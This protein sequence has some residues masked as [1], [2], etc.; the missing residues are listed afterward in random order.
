MLSDVMSHLP[1]SLKL[2]PSNLHLFGPL[3]Q[4]TIFDNENTVQLH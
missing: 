2:A 4:Q 3:R 1:Q